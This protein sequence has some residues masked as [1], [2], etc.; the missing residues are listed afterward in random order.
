LRLNKYD[1]SAA[2]P[3]GTV[4]FFRFVGFY[5]MKMFRPDIAWSAGWSLLGVKLLEETSQPFF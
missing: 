3:S 4:V 5:R 2:V 1:I